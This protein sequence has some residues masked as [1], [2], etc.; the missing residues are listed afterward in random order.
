MSVKHLLRNLSSTKPGGRT[1]AY[2]ALTRVGTQTE[3]QWITSISNNSY[4]AFGQ[5][6]F[7]DPVAFVWD[8][9]IWDENEDEG[10]TD[11]Q[12]E[13]MR[14]LVSQNRV[15]VRAPHGAG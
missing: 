2:S 11:Y 4:K 14:Q 7:D 12:E 10:P 1:A 8:C 13:I 15:C 9:I 3:S 5:K 6:Y